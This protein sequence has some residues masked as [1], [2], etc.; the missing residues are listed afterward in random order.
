VK[1]EV[2]AQDEDHALGVLQ[3]RRQNPDRGAGGLAE[4]GELEQSSRESRRGAGEGVE[5]NWGRSEKKR[6]GV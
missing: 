4:Q 5:T 2:L 3:G 6:P 1:R